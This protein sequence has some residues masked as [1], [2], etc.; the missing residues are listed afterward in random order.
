MQE[1]NEQFKKVFQQALDAEFKGWDFSYLENRMIMEPLPW[2]YH[3]IVES[4][5]KKAECMLDMGTGGG[6]LL[7][8]LKPLPRH[9][10]ATEA[11]SP[12]VAIA[13]ERLGPLGVKVVAIGSHAAVPFRDEVFDLIIN[14]HEYFSCEELRRILK[15]YGLFIT[16]QVGRCNNIELNQFFGDESY[17]HRPLDLGATKS[18]LVKNGFKIIEAKEKLVKT[19]FKDIGAIIYYLRAIPWQIRGFQVDKNVDRFRKLHEIIQRDGHFLA[20]SHR[21][22]VTA[23]L[24]N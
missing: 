24:A 4:H 6:E 12:N 8:S 1:R 3:S 15:P 11:Y 22:L 16:Q 23:T 7:S 13:K 14:R 10:Y 21:F 5:L 20:H 19:S 9:S 17:K 18:K 2:N